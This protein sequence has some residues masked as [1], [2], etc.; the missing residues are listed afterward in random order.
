MDG[1]IPSENMMFRDYSLSFNISEKDSEEI[2]SIKSYSY[3]RLAKSFEN[4]FQL[5]V[6]NGKFSDS[7]II[8]LLGENGTGKTTLI[9]LLA[10]KTDPDENS[11]N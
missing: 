5:S 4:K 9:Q 3:P 2:K 1:F 10:G 7:E 8:V 11:I 6:E